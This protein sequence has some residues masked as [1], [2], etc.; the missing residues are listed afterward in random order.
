MKSFLVSLILSTTTAVALDHPKLNNP[1]FTFQ[2]VMP[3]TVS[4]ECQTIFLERK[5][6]CGERCSRGLSNGTELVASIVGKEG[7]S[8]MLLLRNKKEKVIF[9]SFRSSD[10]WDNWIYDFMMWKTRL[11]GWKNSKYPPKNIPSNVRI[12]YGLVKTYNLMRIPMLEAVNHE[13]NLHKDYKIVFAGLSL[14]AAEALLAMVDFNDQFGFTDRIYA[15]TYGTPRIG[16]KYFNKYADKLLGQNTYRIASH[17]DPVLVM[18]AKWLGYYHI[19]RQFSFK[20]YGGADG[21]IRECSRN[22]EGESPDCYHK[23]KESNPIRHYDY[24]RWAGKC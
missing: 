5:Y 15:Y 9:A 23:T 1:P 13:A 21:K 7:F 10:G 6:S 14:G 3:V 20:T 8:S 16:N 19:G 12:H 18:P 17:G 2:E 4:P 24:Y 11:R 22:R